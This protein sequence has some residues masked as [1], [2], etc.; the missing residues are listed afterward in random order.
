MFFRQLFDPVSSTLTY[1]IAD[2]S[3]HE[4]VLIDPVVEQAER[5][6]RLLREHGL[7][8]KYTLE[9]H[10]HADHV[11]AAQALKRAT[12]AQTAVSRDCNAQGY[13]RLLQDGDVILFGNEEILTIATP[14]HTPGSVSYLW[15][16]RVF[17]GDTL[18]IGGCGRTD[19][20]NGSAESLWHSITEKLFGLDDQ[21]LVYPGHDYKGRRVSSIG[22]E[23]RFNAR[24]AS[25][26]RDEFLAIMSQ[27][28]LPMPARIH[29]AVP[30]NLGAGADQPAVERASEQWAALENRVAVQNVSAQQL[31]EALRNPG[32]RLLD[33]RT[34]AEFESVRIAGA[35][36]VPLDRL[37]P[38]G[39]L[40]SMGADARVYCVCQ[41]GTR[42]QLATAA[43]RAAGFTRVVHVDGGTNAWAMAGLPV[44]RGR[45]V[46]A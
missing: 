17:T 7:T 12:G 16:D 28:N 29:E 34:P 45:S 23:K 30:S 13:D 22:E 20:Q 37:D 10:V 41:T 44:V 32:I 35:V 2:D 18:L 4:A 3:S 39:L 43:L 33:V 21:I 5:D 46:R 6:V 14:G 1:L 36:N 24:V 15:R 42:S 8:L 9:T 11:T 27:L 19:F 40:S 25:K 31:A 38:A 26:T